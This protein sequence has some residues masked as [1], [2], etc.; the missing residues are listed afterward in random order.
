MTVSLDTVIYLVFVA[1][2]WGATNPLIKK[3]SQ[4][5]E[6]VKDPSPW[7]QTSKEIVYL[8]TNLRYVIPFILNQCGSLL[9]FFALQN[10]DLSL[11]VPVTNSLTFVF[12]GITGWI[13][14]EERVHK[15]T[16]FG[17]IMILCGSTLC[18]LDKVG[19][20]NDRDL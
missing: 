8:F 20:T 5:I 19:M 3:G 7:R 2:L 18:C 6:S 15:N 11:A 9:Y 1:I 4:G 16:Y 13:L 12:T 10:A 17:M 14:G